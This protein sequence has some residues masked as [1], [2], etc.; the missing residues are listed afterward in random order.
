VKLMFSPE[1]WRDY[2]LWAEADEAVLTRINS[3]VKECIRTPFTGIGKP[4]PLRN[5]YKGWWSRRITQE[6]R[7]VYR[8]HGMG[9]DQ[10]LEV[11]SCKR[12]Y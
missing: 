3:L 6:D 1:A 5:E 2:L 8:V 10:V 7:L 12:H 4:E 9:S 11:L